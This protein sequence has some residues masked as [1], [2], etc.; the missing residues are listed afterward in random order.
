VVHLVKLRANKPTANQGSRISAHAVTPAYFASAKA[1]PG[2]SGLWNLDMV[3]G[4]ATLANPSEH[5]KGFTVPIR[6]MLGCIS[7]A[8]SGDDQFRGTDLGPYGGNL[9]YNENVEGA[10]LYFPVSHPGALFGVGDAHAAMGDGEL[11]GAALETSADVEFTVDVI[12]GEQTQQVR[13]EN[14]DYLMSFGVAGSL[15]DSLELATTQ[16]VGWL[17]KDYAMTDSEVA[18]F[19]G[20]VLKYDVTEMVDPHWDVVAKVPKAALVNLKKVGGQ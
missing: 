14:K 16:L 1:D 9:D 18:L 4:V 6:T 7:V 20:A 11:T 13:S 19:L 15:Q 5:L 10:T 12:K 17:K 8:P 2:F 3:K